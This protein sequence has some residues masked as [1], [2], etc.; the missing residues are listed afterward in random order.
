MIKQQYL[1]PWQFTPR[2]VE[3]ILSQPKEFVPEKN[4]EFRSEKDSTTL[5][6][7]SRVNFKREPTPCISMRYKASGSPK[8]IESYSSAFLL[9]NRRVRGIDFSPIERKKRYI[10]V[11]PKGWHEN[12]VDPAYPEKDLT[13]GNRHAALPG[14]F[15]PSDLAQFHKACSK[16]WNIKLENGNELF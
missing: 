13:K 3:E 15:S 2:K 7:L 8:L 9:N 1:L 5:T 10:T 12:I 14:D 6:C 4:P 11:I 16:R